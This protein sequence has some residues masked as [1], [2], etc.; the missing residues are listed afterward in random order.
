MFERFHKFIGEVRGKGLMIGI[1][2][3]KDKAS[4]E[5]YPEFVKS[6]KHN[7]LQKGLL[8]EVG[9]HYGNV[10]RLVPPLIITRTIIDNAMNIFRDV[11]E[12][13]EEGHTKKIENGRPL[14][15]AK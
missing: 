2:M 3:V 15:F 10:I 12:F 6:F 14:E 9:G 5:P 13:M 1:E 11:L 8:F 4:K 7:C